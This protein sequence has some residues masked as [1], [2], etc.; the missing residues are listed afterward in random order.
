MLFTKIYINHASKYV[1]LLQFKGAAPKVSKPKAVPKKKANATPAGGVQ[2]NKKAA[3]RP[4][5]AKA[6][7]VK[8][9]TTKKSA[10]T[11]TKNKKSAA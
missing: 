9:K 4:K 7:S 11:H 2:K 10:V 3:G 1:T 8:S 6:S 5:K